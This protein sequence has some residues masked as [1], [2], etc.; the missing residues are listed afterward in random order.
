MVL[1]L[2]LLF[3]P[4]TFAKGL[5]TDKVTLNVQKVPLR[6]AIQQLVSQGD[7]DFVYDEH[8]IGAQKVSCRLRDKPIHIILDRLLA[9][10]PVSFE[11]FENKRIIL[12]KGTGPEEFRFKIYGTISD[13][14]T[15]EPI[16]TANVFLANT[17]LGSATNQRGEFLI[18]NVPLGTFDLVVS[19]LGYSVA[20]T[21]L[22]VYKTI[23]DTIRIALDPKPYQA[24]EIEIS[25]QAMK[26][27]RKQYKKFRKLFF[28]ET[29]NAETCRILNEGV[30]D[31][32]QKNKGLFVADAV[33][34]LVIENKALGYR[35]N[36]I[37]EIFTASPSLITMRG[38]SKYEEMVPKTPDENLLW[39]RNRKRAYRGSLKHFLATLFKTKR[40]TSLSNTNM[41]VDN[42]FLLQ[43]GFRV[44]EVR[45]PWR[46]RDKINVDNPEH[47]LK[48]RGNA[49]QSVLTFSH[50][51]MVHY[52]REK[53]P[54]DYYNFGSR[55]GFPNQQVS[56][57]TL[58]QDSVV[59][60]RSG[61]VYDDNGLRVD[62]YGIRT[63]GY[64]SW[65]R[66]ADRMPWDYAQSVHVSQTQVTP[67]STT[68]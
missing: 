59:V 3:V 32:S 42:N 11:I 31:F 19:R 60:D 20:K 29:Q 22:L 14:A 36:Y 41:V 5:D 8:L 37:M 30:L 21:K 54:R 67:K 15:G 51:L 52:T 26:Q 35:M 50:Y 68:N 56:F 12:A 63:Y 61:N 57:I 17:T 58:T 49:G 16:E 25:A 45:D 40:L 13:E 62:G 64:W 28:S 55:F 33:E 10:T 43:A 39:S 2:L 4:H 34:P 7:Y 27:W 66:M 47:L 44:F 9:G 18:T 6:M 38:F 1:L 23:N 53:P 24:P 48:S 46:S 65:E